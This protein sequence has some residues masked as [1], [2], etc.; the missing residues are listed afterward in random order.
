MPSILRRLS[1]RFDNGLRL[2]KGQRIA[3]QA[4]GVID[5]SGRQI[6]CGCASRSKGSFPHGSPIGPE[7][8]MIRSHPHNDL[9]RDE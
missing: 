8:G 7:G 5:G 2:L 9:R 3:F 4:I 1:M 6:I